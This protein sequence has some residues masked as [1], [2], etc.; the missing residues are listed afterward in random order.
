MLI[1]ASR[2]M[3]CQGSGI[4]RFQGDQRV[5]PSQ[6]I[7]K[8]RNT[9]LKESRKSKC[10]RKKLPRF[11]KRPPSSPGKRMPRTGNRLLRFKKAQHMSIS[12]AVRDFI[13][14]CRK[15]KLNSR[16]PN[17]NGVPE[18]KESPQ[19]FNVSRD[20]SPI[21]ESSLFTIDSLFGDAVVACE[22]GSGGLVLQF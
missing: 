7:D 15:V 17:A 12:S 8:K 21:P 14:A 9:P 13:P 2:S 3:S 16:Q 19:I 10:D 5:K 1:F 18:R 11:A 22:I 6:A 4:C 20:A